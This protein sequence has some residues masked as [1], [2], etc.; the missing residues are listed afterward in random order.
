MNFRR[1][2][3]GPDNIGELLETLF[4]ANNLQG[5]CG[6]RSKRLETPSYGPAYMMTAYFPEHVVQFVEQ[7]DRKLKGLYGPIILSGNEERT[8]Q[9]RNSER[10]AEYARQCAQARRR[11]SQEMGAEREQQLQLQEGQ[12]YLPPPTQ[13]PGGQWATEEDLAAPATPDPARTASV[14]PPTPAPTASAVPTATASAARPPKVDMNHHFPTMLAMVLYLTPNSIPNSLVERPMRIWNRFQWQNATKSMKSHFHRA[15]KRM[16]AQLR[17]YHRDEK[18]P[19]LPAKLVTALEETREE[20]K[21]RLAAA[22]QAK[23]A[24]G[25]LTLRAPQ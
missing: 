13:A 22:I 19:N 9:Q 7:S 14:A 8:R 6:G 1:P 4:A 5:T 23:V 18:L 11:Q 17:N 10:R 24:N 3:V 21:A 12:L 15:L 20:V 25:Y 2:Q 16:A